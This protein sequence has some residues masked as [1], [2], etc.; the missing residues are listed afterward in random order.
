ML[1][2]LEISKIIEGAPNYTFVK[3]DIK[4]AEFFGLN[5]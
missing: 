3:A 5:F 2:N 1:E 4:D